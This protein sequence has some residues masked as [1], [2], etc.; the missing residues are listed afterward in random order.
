MFQV[1]QKSLCTGKNH[2]D[3]CSDGSDV[4]R[5]IISA[6]S[7]VYSNQSEKTHLCIYQCLTHYCINHFKL[8]LFFWYSKML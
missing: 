1:V 8:L 6:L 5:W 7:C 4:I 3:N 2:L